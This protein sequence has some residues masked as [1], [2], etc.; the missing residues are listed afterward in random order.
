[1][2]RF[3]DQAKIYVRSGAGGSGCVSF[4]REKYVEYGGPDGGD[5]GR[6]GD[7]VFEAVNG[8]GTLIDFRH[9]QHF[10]ARRGADGAGKNRTGPSALPLVIKVPVGTEVLADDETLLLDLD[11]AQASETLLPGGDGGQGNARFASST[12]RAP[13]TATEG[14][15]AREMWVRLRLKLLADAGLVGLPNAGKSTF[16]SAVSGARPK[17]ASYP[18]TTL[19]PGLGVVRLGVD[20]EFVMADI[21]GLIEGAHQGAGIGDQFLGHVERCAVLLHIVDGTLDDVGEAY[22][23]IRNELALY[24]AGVADKPEVVALGKID[25]LVPE[26]IEE[27]RKALIRAVEKNALA[28]SSVSGA[29]VQEALSVLAGH[30]RKMRGSV[31]A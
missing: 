1:M 20:E 12:N 13:R 14:G 29:G 19:T 26:E 9:R 22:R 3:L 30:V 16:L 10:K 7:I 24:G 11:H 6:G 21:P 2:S 31:V 28:L 17:I 25:A 15:A 18:F 4:R 27:K 8:A 23:T 5:G